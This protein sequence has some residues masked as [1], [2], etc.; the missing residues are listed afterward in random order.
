M[1]KRPAGGEMAGRPVGNGVDLG[2]VGQLPAGK[3]ATLGLAKLLRP[4]VVCKVHHLV[5]FLLILHLK[6]K[7][8]I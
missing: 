3:G 5:D 2:P 7:Q 1:G 4:L 8:D 6:Q